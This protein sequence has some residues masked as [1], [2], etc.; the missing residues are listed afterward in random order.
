MNYSISS[1][2]NVAACDALITMVTK[3]KSDH[4]FRKLSLTRQLE[5]LATNSVEDS[6]ELTR[7]ISELNTIIPIIDTLEPSDYKTDLISKRMKLES[8]K[9]DLENKVA[10]YDI[11]SR[12]EKEL[13]I[14]NVEASLTN[15]N[16]LLTDLE[17]KR[18]A[19]ST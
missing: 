16:G 17:T 9:F 11:K 10:D 3:E 4:E 1:I 15:I 8:K 7:I 12:F 6:A 19:L 13:D 5:S 2:Q 14:N 18:S